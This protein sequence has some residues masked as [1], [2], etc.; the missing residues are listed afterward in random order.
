MNP[1]APGYTTVPLRQPDVH[2]DVLLV[3]VTVFILTSVGRFHQLFPALLPL[4]PTLMAGLLALALYGLDTRQSRRLHMIESRTTTWGLALLIWVALS[5]PGSLWPGGSLGLLVG[6]FI[7]TVLMYLV[8]VG[9][10]R[11]TRDVERL[12]WMYF[13]AAVVF[14]AV[15]LVRF[16][17]AGGGDR[18]DHFPYYDAN[19]FGVFAVTALPLGLYF[20]VSQSRVHLRILACAGL[21]VLLFAFVQAGSRG[22]FVAL[23]AV[24]AFFLLRQTTIPTRWRVAGALVIAVLFVAAASDKYWQQMGTILH[25]SE[26]YNLTSETGRL[27]IW[28]R[29]IGYMVDNPIF[30]VGAGSFGTAEGRLSGINHWT[31]P[32]N[33]YVQ[34][35]AELG[36]PGLV[37][38]VGFIAAALAALRR[39][40]R[41]FASKAPAP[42]QSRLAQALMASIIGF[43]VGAFFLSLAYAGMLWTLAALAMGLAKVTGTARQPRRARLPSALHGPAPAPQ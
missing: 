21:A 29:G 35:G 2:W 13:L 9:A 16:Y 40:E 28:S 8:L 14:A 11:G 36:I 27:Q 39:V 32:H 20:A 42:M 6:D 41:A 26:D 37:F 33:A 24:F 5:V 18:M 23:M 43:V 19:D 25:T 4:R 22:G 10:V 1:Q 34:L 31:A 30:G 17:G 15:G 7:K 38:F 3:C 12:A